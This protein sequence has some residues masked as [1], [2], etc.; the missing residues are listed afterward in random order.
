MRNFVQFRSAQTLPDAALASS[1]VSGPSDAE[2]RDGVQLTNLD[3]P[4]FEGAG[5]TKRDLVEYLAVR[6]GVGMRGASCV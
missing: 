5:A 6:R 3:Q 2:R 1:P 4:L